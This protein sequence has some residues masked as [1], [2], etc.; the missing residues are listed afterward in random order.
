MWT[1]SYVGE[2]GGCT[3]GLGTEVGVGCIKDTYDVQLITVLYISSF[4]VQ[5]LFLKR[6][7]S[8]SRHIVSSN[9][10]T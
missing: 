3:R 6:E 10:D 5:P 1:A 7:N 4:V 9:S 2:V 8:S